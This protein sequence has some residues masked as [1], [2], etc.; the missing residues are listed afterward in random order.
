[1]T[2]LVT[3]ERA[4]PPVT[5]RAAA[6]AAWQ[7]PLARAAVLPSESRSSAGLA[8]LSKAR[9]TCHAKRKPPRITIVHIG[10]GRQ[11][12]GFKLQSQ[13]AII[14]SEMTSSESESCAAASRD[15]NVHRQP[16]SAALTLPFLRHYF[17][18]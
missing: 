13:A 9:L 2:A 3:R 8:Q 15:V 1:M 18:K 4:P 5:D 10:S 17:G 12:T 11:F 14:D 7:G 6:G 16:A